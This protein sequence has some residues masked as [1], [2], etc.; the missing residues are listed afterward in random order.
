VE[1]L[2]N[3]MS[4]AF[5]VNYVYGFSS[6]GVTLS[7]IALL[8][9]LLYWIGVGLWC[10]VEDK[11]AVDVVPECCRN[12]DLEQ[13]ECRCYLPERLQTSG[14]WVYLDWCDKW[15]KLD[16]VKY[17]LDVGIGFMLFCVPLGIVV[18]STILGIII[19]ALIWAPVVFS[20]IFSS[21]GLLFLA[22]GVRR[23]QKKLN[24]HVADINAHV[25]DKESDNGDNQK[26]Q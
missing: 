11:K 22:R 18:C 10:F 21:V 7:L 2:F 8:C 12:V 4:S 24:A 15:Y 5:S 26:S 16:T 20:V 9:Y 19:E 14:D 1:I 23:L 6:V 3:W 17:K 13:S 25:E